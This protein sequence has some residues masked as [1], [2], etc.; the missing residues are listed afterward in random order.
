[1]R[2]EGYYVKG[3]STDT[4]WDRTSDFPVCS[5]VPQPTS[6]PGAQCFADSQTILLADNRKE[7]VNC[8]LPT[9]CF[10]YLTRCLEVSL[11]I[12]FPYSCVFTF[13]VHLLLN[14]SYRGADKSLA[15]PGRIKAR[16]H[17]KDSREFNKIETR[18]VIKSPRFHKGRGRRKLTPC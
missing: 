2:S 5:S 6:Q 10:P 17:V 3:K 8:H 12:M 11:I 13:H 18:A 4:S 1:M 16:R 9:N 14:G 15:P 7:N